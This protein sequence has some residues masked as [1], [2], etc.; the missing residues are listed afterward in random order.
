MENGI[1]E[2]GIMENGIMETWNNQ[3]IIESNEISLGKRN[4]NE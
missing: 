4:G 3:I 1:R 2:N